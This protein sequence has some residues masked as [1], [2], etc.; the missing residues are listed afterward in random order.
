[1]RLEI[2]RVSV[3]YG[4]ALALRDVS[5]TVPSGSVVA[6]LGP[7]GAGKTTLLRA[8]SGLVGMRSGRLL[9]EREDLTGASHDDLA[10]RGVCHI[11]EGRSVFPGLTVRENL[12][13]F[14]TK[15]EAGLALDRAV[16]AFP[17]LG[18]RLSQIAG[19][20]S[21]GEQQM[22]AMARAYVRAAPFV[23]L[24]EPSMG[25]AP[26][27]IDEIFVFL[28][29]L[30]AE[31]SSVLIAEQY[32]GRALALADTV[33]ILSRGRVVFAGEPAELEGEAVFDH[34]VSASANG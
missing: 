9:V 30:A 28:E 23:M 26:I 14:A 21:G 34:Y 29:R 2:D 27:V 19:T 15:A 11:T 31:G 33:Y 20:M 16:Q 25:L 6:L 24:D 22:L 32:V 18:Q 10:R 1:M 13:L 17:K 12:R 4:S 3:A 7:N 5:L 8:A